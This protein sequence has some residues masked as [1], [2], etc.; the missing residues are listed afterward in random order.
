MSEDRPSAPPRLEWEPQ[1]TRTLQQRCDTIR[2]RRSLT[3]MLMTLIA[4]GSAQLAAGSKRVGR[5]AL[6]TSLTLLAGAVTLGIVALVDRRTLFS[7]VTDPTLLLVARFVL[8]VLAVAWILLLTDAWR[9]GDPL[10]LRRQ[11]RVA[12]VGVNTCLCMVTGGALLFSAHLVA[13]E[14]DL[15]TSV[16]TGEQVTDPY[17][18]RYNVLLLGGDSGRDRWGLRPDSIN[19]A[20]IDEQTGRTVLFSLPRNLRNV[21]FAE[22][23]VMAEQFPDGFDCKDCYLNGVYT[24]A[25]DH[26]E[27]WGREVRDVG[28]QATEE[29]V[30]GITGLDINYYAMVNLAGFTDLVDAVGGV[31]I[32]VEKPIPIGGIGAPIEGY[33]EPGRQRLD[34]F[35]ALWYARSRVEDDDYARMGR[36][37]CVMSAMLQQLSPATVV[38]QVQDIA[39]AGKRLLETDVP[40]SE[41]DT[42]ID[43]ALKARSLPVSSVSFVPPRIQTSDPDFELVRTMVDE[44]LQKANGTYERPVDTTPRKRRG[45]A[46]RNSTDDLASTC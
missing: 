1:A 14:R 3:L 29:A 6:R 38:L 37:K 28:V 39:S 34:G 46:A 12:L 45:A 11:H 13:V 43:L 15:I 8:V 4:P 23:G 44:A 9:L 40:A 36:Q 7:L 30:E 27:L 19:V 25:L 41:L 42:F 22:G 16:F 35:D 17:D 20:S 2:L 26:K 31:R 18:G 5:I 33:I 21:P 24:W 10:R 32:D